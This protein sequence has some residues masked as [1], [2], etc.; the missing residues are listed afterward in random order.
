M[1]IRLMGMIGALLLMSTLAEAADTAKV[2]GS[3]QSAR[4]PVAGAFVII[5]QEL[6]DLQKEKLAT[7]WKPFVATAKTGSDGAYGFDAVPVG[8]FSICAQVPGSDLINGCQ[9]SEGVV[10]V[11]V[12]AAGSATA[13]PITLTQGYLV[14]IKVEDPQGLAA[15]AEGR[16]A[17]PAM[18]V[19]V[20]G[21]G[22]FFHEARE[23]K[24]DSK[25]REY[26]LLVP[27][28]V[29]LSVGA[30]SEKL[31]IASPD[32]TEASGLGAIDGTIAKGETRQVYRLV[33][34]GNKAK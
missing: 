33:V 32:G 15:K 14:K 11:K 26:E 31:S 12:A 9:W 4:G 5:S 20:W 3:V 25:G 18:R 10:R 30:T 1:W 8:T 21:P 13:A 7:N 19:G 17:K 22:R 34:K 29:V 6:P 27:Y 16:T 23:T 24:L 2:F 28:E